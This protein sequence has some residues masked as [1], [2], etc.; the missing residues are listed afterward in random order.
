VRPTKRCL[1]DLGLKFPDLAVQLHETADPVVVRAQLIPSEVA[2]GGAE[3]VTSLSDRVWFKCKTSDRC[4]I[5][6]ELGAA[7]SV[8][9]ADEL[10]EA[11]WWIGAAG[12][13]RQGSKQDFYSRLQDEVQRAGKGTGDVSSR[14]LLPNEADFKRLEYERTTQA[15]LS[16]HRVVRSLIAK[17]LRDGRIWAATLSGHQ[18]SAAVR[19]KDGDAYLAVLAEGFVDARFIA[20]ILRA[21]PDIPATD[22]LPK[23]DG[24]MGISPEPGQIIYSTM[25]PPSVQAVLLAEF[26]DEGM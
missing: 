8:V 1:D 3:R 23:P 10:D 21:V 13:R 12:V 16:I 5:V 15:V 7:D 22:W 14:H 11:S 24:A 9:A 25:I 17:S 6:T 26:A 18:I 20:V 4:A 2:C 19:T